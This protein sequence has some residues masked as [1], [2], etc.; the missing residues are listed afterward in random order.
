ME[1]GVLYARRVRCEKVVD[2]YNLHLYDMPILKNR[3]LVMNEADRVL[4]IL[5]CIHLGSVVLLPFV[6]LLYYYIRAALSDL[7]HYGYVNRSSISD[8]KLSRDSDLY[9][10]SS[11]IIF[12]SLISPLIIFY[13]VVALTWNLLGAFVGLMCKPLGRWG[14]GSGGLFLAMIR[15]VGIKVK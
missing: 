14:T 3:G 7:K 8:A 2:S 1:G 12:H 9:Y 6:S 4:V 11:D 13:M 5:A 15:L 10:D